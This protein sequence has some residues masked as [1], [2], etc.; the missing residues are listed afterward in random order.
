VNKRAR[1]YSADNGSV[2]T[3][4]DTKDMI[5]ALAFASPRNTPHLFVANGGA[6]KA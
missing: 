6:I 5:N 1:V 4:F 2:I 3:T